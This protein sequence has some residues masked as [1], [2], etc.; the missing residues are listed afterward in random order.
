MK[1]TTLLYHDVVQPGEQASSGFVSPAADAYKIEAPVFLRHLAAIAETGCGP[2]LGVVDALRA[3]TTDP[4]LFTVDDGGVTSATEIAPAL[5]RRGWVGHFFITTGQIGAAGF[6]SERQLRELDRA[7]H[8]VGSH[9]ESH[10][11]RM[12]RVPYP[13]LVEEWTRSR[14]ALERV[15]EKSVV[16]ASVPGGHYSRTVARAAFEAGYRI[17][18]T[19]E[20]QRRVEQVEGCTVLGRFCVKRGTPDDEVVGLVE[21]RG[22]HRRRHWVQWNTKKVA[23]VVGG[24]LYLW[25]QSVLAARSRPSA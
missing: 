15:L 5:E 3:S 14:E 1:L 17:L 18:F 20:P 11:A 8:V 12:S 2:A 7:G 22:S 6:V 23:K 25:L 24:P 16:V 21:G 13:R 19:S 10:P 9:T 4:W